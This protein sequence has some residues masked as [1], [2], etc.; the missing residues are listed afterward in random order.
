MAVLPRP[1]QG[2]G[3]AAPRTVR[4]LR[5]RGGRRAAASPR[6][7]E[8]HPWISQRRAR[9]PSGGR[10]AELR[11]PWETARLDVVRPPDCDAH[12]SAR[13]GLDGPR[14]RLRRH[15]RGRAAVGAH[16]RARAFCAVDTAFTDDLI[17]A[18][19][20]ASRRH[21]ALRLYASLDDMPAP[22]RPVALV[23]LMDVIEHIDDPC[24]FLRGVGRPAVHRPP[25][26]IPH[27]RAG[28]PVALLSRTTRSSVTIGA[29]R[30]R[31]LR[32]HAAASGLDVV[33]VGYFFFS[34]LPLRL[35]QVLKERLSRRKA[36]GCDDR[37]RDVGRGAG[38]GRACCGGLLVCDASA[39]SLAEA[40]RHHRCPACPT[41]PICRKS[42]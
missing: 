2:H 16:T 25:H 34:L 38:I 37:A 12:V 11:H 41:T 5:G 3:A 42:A 14:R 28:V 31:L 9:G 35:A 23:L 4:R 15:V 29:I 39:G 6:H 21:Y 18:Y 24:G 27:H 1:R 17:A 7:G 20:R 10:V 33:E 32:Q 30:A 26:A 8:A 13:P 19:R 40:H 22:D 36:A